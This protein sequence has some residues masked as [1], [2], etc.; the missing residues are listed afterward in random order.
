M[1]EV[2]CAKHKYIPPRAA[3]NPKCPY[4]PDPLINTRDESSPI[5]AAS[6]T[7]LSDLVPYTWLDPL[8][9]GDKPALTGEA[10]RWGC[11]DVTNLLK[12]IRL[13]IRT[14]ELLLRENRDA[15]I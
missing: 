1:T 13:R 4:C 5:E 6:K 3:K 2:F 10:G 14:Q 9:T 7:P 15:G 8:L 12:A 11:P